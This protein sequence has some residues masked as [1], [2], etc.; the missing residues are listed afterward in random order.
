M[1]FGG[2]S[3]LGE[4]VELPPIEPAEGCQCL[5]LR[6]SFAALVLQCE[7]ERRQN[8]G[9]VLRGGVPLLLIGE[10]GIDGFGGGGGV[11]DGVA[12]GGSPRLG[13]FSVG[14]CD[15]ND[16]AG[17]FG[18]ELVGVFGPGQIRQVLHPFWFRRTI[19]G[20][21]VAFTDCVNCA[22]KSPGLVLRFDQLGNFQADGS[23]Q[24]G[25]GVHF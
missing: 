9:D 19:A 8:G 14:L 1:G 23:S 12:G 7:R 24:G 18:P 10:R 17:F 16:G 13:L 20:A 25:T 22:W 11:H 2:Y 3:S 6:E 21:V 15:P 4:I 5:R